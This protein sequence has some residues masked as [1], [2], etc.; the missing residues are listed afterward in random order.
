MK[1]YTITYSGN[2]SEFKGREFEVNANS[3]R[4]AVEGFY[5]DYCPGDYWPQEDGSIQNSIGDVIAEPEDDSIYHDGGYF[6]A[7]VEEDEDE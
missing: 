4:E 6:S 7:E 1:T 5:S 2:N 3:E